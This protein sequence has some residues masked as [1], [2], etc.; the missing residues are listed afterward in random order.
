MGEIMLKSGLILIFIAAIMYFG[1]M[2]T[3]FANEKLA[4][5]L[6]P[7]AVVLALLGSI[8]IIIGVVKDRIVEK[9][10]E[11]EDDLSKY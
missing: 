5:T 10:E 4:V 9:E 6:F 1:G 3:V 2:L 11:D 8:L 7:S